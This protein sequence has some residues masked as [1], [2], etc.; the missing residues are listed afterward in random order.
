[1]IKFNVFFATSK[2][3]IQ[4]FTVAATS[5]LENNKGLDI[6][7]Y[8]IHDNI[9]I[10]EFE[11]IIH[12]FKTNYKTELKLINIGHIDFSVFKPTLEYPKYTYFR[13][14][15]AVIAP[16]DIETALFLDSDLVVTGDISELANID[17]TGKYICAVSEASVADNVKR[18]QA[19][20]S[21][22]KSYFNAGV[23]LVNLKW[24]RRKKITEKF[25]TIANTYT[26]LDWVDQDILNICFANQWTKIDEKYNAVHLI[27]KKAVTPIII[28]YASYSKPWI[29]ADTHPYNNLYWQYLRLTPFKKYKAAGFSLHNF[30]MKFGRLTKRWL[31]EAKVIKYDDKYK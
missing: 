22:A 14:F 15:L 5:L 8:V 19:L 28:H 12:F 13:L 1:M 11:K 23:I 27:R 6:N 31:R 2:S 29:Y 24:W 21:V 30:I 20:G 26:K 18:L 9:N 16:T 17:L 3:Y 10:I 7:L 25:I 4:H